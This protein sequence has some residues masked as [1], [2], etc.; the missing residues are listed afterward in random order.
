MK[1]VVVTFGLISGTVSSALML[2]TVPFINR[3]GFDKHGAIIGYTA[4]VASFLLVFFGVRSCRDNVAG[5]A[6]TFGRAFAVGFLITLISFSLHVITWEFIYFKLAPDFADKY[7][8]YAIER[9]RASGASAEQIAATTR[10]MAFTEP[11][12]IGLAVTLIS[13]AVLRRPRVP[14]AASLN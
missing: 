1:R 9:A 13:A 3:I 12:P 11:F 7:A 2:M 6:V 4:I 14:P 5:G 8:A 10:E